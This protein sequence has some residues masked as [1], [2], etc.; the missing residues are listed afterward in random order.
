MKSMKIVVMAV[1]ATLSLAACGPSYPRRNPGSLC[2]MSERGNV[3]KA[4][5]DGHRLTC[6][7]TYADRVLRWR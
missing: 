6:S 2:S 5:T 7:A 1:V 4:T 3:A